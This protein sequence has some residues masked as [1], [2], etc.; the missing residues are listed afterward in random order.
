MMNDIIQIGQKM[1]NLAPYEKNDIISN[2]Y[3]KLGDALVRI[4]TVFSAKNM[5]E[6][7]RKTG[8]KKEII[9]ALID[10]V[11]KQ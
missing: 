6:L 8:L 2:A 9:I 3:S 10:R 4:G 5:D 7:E 1:M 11:K